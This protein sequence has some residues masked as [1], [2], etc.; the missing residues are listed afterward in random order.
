MGYYGTYSSKKQIVNEV[1][2]SYG[3]AVLAHHV[4]REALYVALKTEIL[5]YRIEKHEDGYY[6]K[7][8]SEG[9]NP[10]YYDCPLKLLAL[11]PGSGT[12]YSQEWRDRV[13]IL[14]ARKKRTY[15]A[16]QQVQIYGKVYEVVGQVKRSYTVKDLQTGKV[17]RATTRIMEAV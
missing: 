4:S 17:Y 11:C 14:D 1:L 2:A 3:E 6:Y 7:P 16:G 8:M 15:Q 12:P 5:V 9:M 13:R 10:F